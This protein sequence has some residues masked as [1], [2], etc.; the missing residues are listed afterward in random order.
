MA[1][2]TRRCGWCNTD[3]SHMQ[4]RAKYCCRQHMKNAGS[5]RHRERNP[6]YYKKFRAN[7]PEYYKQYRDNNR[8]R[9][10]A[11]ARE[12]QRKYRATHPTHAANWWNANQDKHRAYQQKRRA[13]KNS[14]PGSVGV[15]QRDWDRLARRYRYCC[16]YCN[17]KP[18]LLHMDH[19]IPL[20]RGGRHAI[21]NVLP[22]CKKC[23]TSKNARL[24]ADWKYR[25]LVSRSPG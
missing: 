23:N 20:K 14:N 7:H 24:L 15:S 8:E 2:H 5:K 16:A 17:K 4:A 11:Y 12:Q 25:E 1:Q 22:A 21:G 10:L 13:A 3:I 6:D 18:R 19:V 9:R